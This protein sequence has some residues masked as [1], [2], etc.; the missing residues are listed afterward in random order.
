[1][2]LYL[3]K[4]LIKKRGGGSMP[5]G[6]KI[7]KSGGYLMSNEFKVEMKREGW[8]RVVKYLRCVNLPEFNEGND[9]QFEFYESK[10]LDVLAFFT[11]WIVNNGVYDVVIWLGSGKRSLV[12][13]GCSVEWMYMDDLSGYEGEEYGLRREVKVRV[14]LRYVRVFIEDKKKGEKCVIG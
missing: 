2:K 14:G 4:R 11:D 9:L 10:D 12:F 7:V 3:E 13:T 8:D 5:R 6:R 1:M